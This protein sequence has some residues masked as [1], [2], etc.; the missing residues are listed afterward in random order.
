VPRLPEALESA[1]YRVAQEALMNVT[2]H[3]GPSRVSV[4]LHRTPRVVRLVV[5]DDGKGFDSSV[6]H[7]D[8]QLGLVGMRERAHLIGG[9]MTV[10]SSAG[11][12]TTICVSVPLPTA[13]VPS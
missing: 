4:L 2:K 10:E 1:L 11:R 3:A 8:R 9:A 12:G 7:S 13:P 6:A 5:E